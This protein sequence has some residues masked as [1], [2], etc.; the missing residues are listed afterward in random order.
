MKITNYQLFWEDLFLVLQELMPIALKEKIVFKIYDEEITSYF[1][2]KKWNNRRY[3]PPG[4]RMNVVSVQKNPRY[5][6]QLEKFVVELC[7]FKESA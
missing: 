2:N 4:K 3:I 6:Y 5:V 1:R 7:N